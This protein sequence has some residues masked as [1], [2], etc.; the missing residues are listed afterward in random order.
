[1][2]VVKDGEEDFNQGAPLIAMGI[3]TAAMES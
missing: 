3:E 2:T 1:M